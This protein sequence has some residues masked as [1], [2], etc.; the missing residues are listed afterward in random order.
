MR[1]SLKKIRISKG[2]LQ[3]DIA[4]AIKISPAFYSL[5]ESGERLPSMKTAKRI[6][7]CMGITLDEFYE[8]L[9]TTIEEKF[10]YIGRD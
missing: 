4:E 9:I 7:L 2:L 1:K 6:A 8:A 5:I 3:K 10:P